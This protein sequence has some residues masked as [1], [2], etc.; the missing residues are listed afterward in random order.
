MNIIGTVSHLIGK[1]IAIQSDGSERT[2]ALGDVIYENE[3]IK[4]SPDA[5]I[6][7]AMVGGDLVVLEKGQTWFASSETYTAIEN[8]DLSEAVIDGDSIDDAISGAISGAEPAQDG[9]VDAIQAAILAG[10]DPTEVAEATAAGAGGDAASGNEGTS[11]VVIDRTAGEVDPNAGYDTI[12]FADTFTQPEEELLGPVDEVLPTVSVS[13]EVSPEDPVDPDDPEV[14]DEPNEAY[15]V[16]VN[17]NNVSILEGSTV[18]DDIPVTRP[19]TFLLTLDKVFDQ[20]VTVTYALV[21]GTATYG[22]DWTNG[23]SPDQIYTTVIPAGTTSIP[24]T[25][26]IIEDK[27]DEGNET[28]DIV[29]LNAENATINP[30]AST[31]MVTIFDDDTTPVANDDANSLNDGE[32]QNF[33][34]AGNVLTNDTD[35]DGDAGPEPGNGILEVV[36]APIVIGHTL[37]ELTIQPDGSYEFALNQA[38]HA[39]L[40]ALGAEGSTDITFTDAYQVTDT[41]N[42]G[43]FADVVITLNGINDDP[44]GE[45]QPLSNYDADVISLDISGAFSDADLPGDTLFFSATGLPAGLS[46][47]AA[48]VIS[49]TIDGSASDATDDDDNTQDYNVVVTVTD[50]EGGSV[51][52][53]FIWTVDNTIPEFL[54]GDD[55]SQTGVNADSYSFSANEGAEADDV[56]GQ[57]DAVDADNDS[58]TYSITGGNESGLFA[59]DA[60]SG[61]ISLT[62][63]IDDAEL[64]LYNLSVLVDDSEG[65][66]DTASVAI[67]LDNINDDPEI[68]STG[69]VTVSE[70]GLLG[71]ILDYSGNLD[72]TN[73]AFDDSGQVVV[74]DVDGGTPTYTLDTPP[75]GLTSGGLALTWSGNGTGTNGLI[76]AT[77]LTGAVT[78]TTIIVISIA[79][80]GVWSADL[81]GPIDHLSTTEED[82]LSFD[83]GVTVS[84][85]NGGSDTATL[86]ITVED[87]SPA[88]SLVNDGS[89]EGANVS[90]SAPNPDASEIFTGQF[91]DWGVGADGFKEANFTLPQNATV[92]SATE[93]QVVISLRD[94]SGVAGILTL[95]ADGEDTLEVFHREG[96]INFIPVAATSASAGGPVGSLLVDLGLATDYNILVSGSDGDGVVEVVSG[97]DDDLVNTSTNGWAVK[98][99]QGQTNQLGESIQFSFVVDSNN[100]T[101]TGIPDFKFTTEGYTGGIS[102]ARILVNVYTN[103]TLT[104]Y[105]QIELIV[106]SGQE[107]QISEQDWSGVGGNASYTLGD[108]IYAVEVVSNEPDGSF[109]LNGIEVGDDQVTPPADL[110]FENLTMEIVDTDGDSASQSFSIYLDGEDPYGGELVLEAVMGTSGHNILTGTIGNDIIQGGAGN[111]ILTGGDGDDEFIWTVADADGGTDIVTDFA[112]DLDDGSAENDVLNLSDLLSDGVSNEIVAAVSGGNLQL[113]VQNQADSSV[114][115]V[116]ELTDVAVANQGEADLLLADLLANNNIDDGIV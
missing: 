39:A 20:D 56:I 48:G 76:G 29:L 54:S 27:L 31:G 110:A 113:T 16:L 57:V 102:E 97:N 82:D 107:V 30:A 18:A 5:T 72:T 26:N 75:A 106:T 80:D 46:M 62:Q 78:S 4:A 22:D 9:D 19:V 68:V 64:G 40:V 90:I 66:Q 109:R 13:V 34:V 2:L 116:I 58:L 38:G 45:L 95:N 112:F 6:E 101:P 92:L 24:V 91:A 89:D 47:S 108:D 36:G 74:T 65:G 111:D 70:E 49:G 93:S 21:S 99:D 3:V 98:G 32:E 11:T 37:G 53:P 84:D 115:Q 7:I 87:D 86:S 63:D 105:D 28:V 41:Y 10:A 17:G 85:G 51:E 69:S 12:G 81:Q 33:I 44:E 52:A 79:A 8:F 50:G 61:E 35:A 100:T 14:P 103:S 104:A 43:N 77:Q 96:E 23:P 42:E 60:S 25:I 94:G 55:N 59:I 83:V 114:L 15:P 73:N 88:F 71:G 67:S 1:V